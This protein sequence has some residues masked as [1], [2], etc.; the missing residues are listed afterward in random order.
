MVSERYHTVLGVVS[1]L[2]LFGLGVWGLQR[3][4]PLSHVLFVLAGALLSLGG[5]SVRVR[6]RIPRY[7]RVSMLLLGIL[8]L[9]ALLVGPESNVLLGLL[10]VSLGYGVD[11]LVERVHHGEWL[12]TDGERPN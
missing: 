5:A 11:T 1:G 8:A 7:K 10:V 2:S 6:T 9:L 4:T 3:S 12:P